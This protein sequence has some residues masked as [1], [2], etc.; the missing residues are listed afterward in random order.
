MVRYII[1]DDAATEAAEEKLQPL[2]ETVEFACEEDLKIDPVYPEAFE[3]MVA[4]LKKEKPDGVVLDL[5]LDEFRP[6]SE[7]GEDRKKPDYRA[8]GL[9]QELRTRSTERDLKELPIVLWSYESKLKKSYTKD[10]TGHDLF[11]LKSKK[12]KLQSVNS[13]TDVA[14]KLIALSKGYEQ[15]LETRKRKGGPGTQFY[16]FLGFDSDPGFL[17][18][19][20]ISYFESH[21]TP[22]PA[23]EYARFII[24]Q[25]LEVPGPLIDEEVL[26]ARLGVDIDKSGEWEELLAKLPESVRYAGPFSEGWKRWW[27]YP[28][29]RWWK[30]LSESSQPLR[31]VEAE[32]RIRVLKAAV[33]ELD[34]VAATP[35][36]PSYSSQFWSVCEGAEPGQIRDPLDPIDGFMITRKDRQ[37][38]QLERY[39]SEERAIEDR[40][41]D[42]NLRI[43]PLERDRLQELKRQRKKEQTKTSA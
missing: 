15:I 39:I 25:L 2:I 5:R 30:S 37:P 28:L 9:A 24:K 26:A 29:E 19:R 6:P 20:L 16:K 10:D 23:H 38:W 35:I 12:E 36:A 22:I 21:D 13:A 33:G 34:L 8:T 7:E 11:D 31:Q 1:V 4:Y 14:R 17:D 27:A 43:D 42:K 3:E 41:R 18:P 32:E 40:H